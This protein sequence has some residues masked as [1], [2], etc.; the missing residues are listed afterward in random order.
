MDRIPGEGIGAGGLLVHPAA[1]GR[2]AN[3]RVRDGTAEGLCAHMVACAWAFL[4]GDSE[5]AD[6][7]TACP[8]ARS[9]RLYRSGRPFGVS[10]AGDPGARGRS[11][12]AM[13]TRNLAKSRR[14][15]A[16]AGRAAAKNGYVPAIHVLLGVSWLWPDRVED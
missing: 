15:I 10:A 1:D 5:L 6:A 2:R 16:A 13:N 12:T 14:D 8:I 7:P 4:G 3:S 9:S 11:G